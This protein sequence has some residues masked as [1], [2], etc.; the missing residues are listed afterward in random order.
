MMRQFIRSRIGSLL[1]VC[2]MAATAPAAL[3][4]ATYYQN[5]DNENNAHTHVADNDMDVS[6]GNAAGIHPIEFNLNVA[7]L[8]MNSSVLTLRAL[9]VDEEQGEVDEVYINGHYLGRLTGANNV[10]SVTSFNIDPAFLV[11]GDNLIEIKVDQGNDPTA[12]VTTIDWA[13]NLVDGGAGVQGDTRSVQ[14]TSTSQNATTVTVNTQT[15]VHSATGGTYRLQISLIDPNGNAVTIS[16]SDFPVAP[17]TDVVRNVSPTYPLS[18]VSGVY[19]V[20]AQLFWLDPAN[21]NFPL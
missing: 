16:T 1:F 21:G 18:S 12:W 13:Q 8:P 19:K 3:A 14:I 17:N 15:T 6:L 11:V 2:C 5:S 7:A 20:E 10:W 9:D 4:Q